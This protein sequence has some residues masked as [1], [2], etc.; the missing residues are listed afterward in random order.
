MTVFSETFK[1][2]SAMLGEALR[3]GMEE[4]TRRN[5]PKSVQNNDEIPS[6]DDGDDVNNA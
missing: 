4:M 2:G 1:M 3:I 6:V 5:C